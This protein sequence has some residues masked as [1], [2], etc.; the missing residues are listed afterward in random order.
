MVAGSML[1]SL[2]TRENLEVR[3]VG[4]KRKKLDFIIEEL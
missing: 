1:M 2:L 4:G 3:K